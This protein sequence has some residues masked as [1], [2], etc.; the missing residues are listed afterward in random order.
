MSHLFRT[1]TLRIWRFRQHVLR[2]WLKLFSTRS[3]VKYLVQLRRDAKA[4][5][6]E[7]GSVCGLVLIFGPIYDWTI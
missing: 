7:V 6:V 4:G 2:V 1:G 5:A 3:L